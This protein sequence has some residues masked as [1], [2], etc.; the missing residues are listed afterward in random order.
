M[1]LAGSAIV[2]SNAEVAKAAHAFGSD[3]IKVGLIGCGRRG[4][5]LLYTSPS[6][7]D[8]TLSRMPSS[9]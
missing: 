3:Q 7:R 9:A 2:G 6:P 8:A 1:I 4:T 5:C